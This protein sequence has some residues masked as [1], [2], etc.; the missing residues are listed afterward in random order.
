MVIFNNITIF[1]ANTFQGD[2]RAL[3]YFRST[4]AACFSVLYFSMLIS[5]SN[6]VYFVLGPVS[7]RFYLGS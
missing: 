5:I 6:S 2:R 4:D 7:Y 3:L 1:N